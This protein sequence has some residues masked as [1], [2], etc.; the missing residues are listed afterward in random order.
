MGAECKGLTFFWGEEGSNKLGI[1][2]KTIF[3]Q[4]C[5]K[6][7]RAFCICM[8]D[9]INICVTVSITNILRNHH[10]LEQKL[11]KC[12]NVLG[13]PSHQVLYTLGRRINNPYHCM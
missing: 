13:G 11:F 2:L 4:F 7:A 8:F 5:L 10:H 6:S 1:C 9:W 3:F 12:I